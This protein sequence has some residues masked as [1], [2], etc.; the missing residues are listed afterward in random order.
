MEFVLE[1]NELTVKP[2][3]VIDSNNAEQVGKEIDDIRTNNKHNSLILDLA[4][5]TYISSAGLRQILKLK[6]TCDDFKICNVCNEVYDIF[7]MTGF[8]EMMTIEKAFRESK[9]SDKN[10]PK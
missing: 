2:E 10:T 9:K 6:K 4:K 1:G 5:L 7:E 3:G 8:S